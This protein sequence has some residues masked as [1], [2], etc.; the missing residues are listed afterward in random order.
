MFAN[1]IPDQD[2]VFI[3]YKQLLQLNVKKINN[4]IN[5]WTKEFSGCFSKEDLQMASEDGKGS[6]HQPLEKPVK[7]TPQ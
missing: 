4:P 5:Q 7:S 3:T 2:L 6:Q 1:H